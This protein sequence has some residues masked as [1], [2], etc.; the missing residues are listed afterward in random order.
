MIKSENEKNKLT[1]GQRWEN[2]RNEQ[3]EIKA[4]FFYLLKEKKDR[5]IDDQV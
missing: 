3:N 4:F 5:S 1:E 2:M